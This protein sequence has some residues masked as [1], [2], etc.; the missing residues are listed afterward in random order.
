MY[1]VYQLGT[2]ITSARFSHPPPNVTITSS[3]ATLVWRLS[4]VIDIAPLLFCNY[5]W[6]CN[7]P[8]VDL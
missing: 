6:F 7:C 4:L 2:M 8:L 5:L 1:L 3:M